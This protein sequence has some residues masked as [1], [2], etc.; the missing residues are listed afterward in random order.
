MIREQRCTLSL[1]AVRRLLATDLGL[2][3]G[4]LDCLKADISV[5]VDAVLA[6]EVRLTCRA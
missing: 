6:A 3:E 1:R 2:A 5:E 4:S